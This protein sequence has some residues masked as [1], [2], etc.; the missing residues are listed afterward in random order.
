[1]RA[2]AFRPESARFARESAVAY[3][4]GAFQRPPARVLLRRALAPPESAVVSLPLCRVI[5]LRRQQGRLGGH[6]YEERERLLLR[7]TPNSASRLRK[8]LD[9]K[10]SSMFIHASRCAA[11]RVRARP[12]RPERGP[13][14]PRRAGRNDVALAI[15]LWSES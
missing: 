2:A 10:E 4:A 3:L 15:A 8:D 7:G 1:M 14:R 9:V 5:S 12:G 6:C 13:R 11:K